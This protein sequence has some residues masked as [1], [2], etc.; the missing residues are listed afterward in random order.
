MVFSSE[1]F[2][3]GFM[4][5]F[6]SLYYLIANRHKNWLI[7]AASLIFY[8]IGEQWFVM[9]MVGSILWNYFMG[10]AIDHC[11]ERARRSL[12]V[13]GVIVNLAVIA[14]FKYGGF[15]I[16]NLNQLLPA[17]HLT[18]VTN[19]KIHLAAGI[20]F[21]TF[22]ALS[23]LIDVYRREVKPMR[24][25]TMNKRMKIQIR[26]QSCPQRL[27]TQLRATPPGRCVPLL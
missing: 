22:H 15:L 12:L 20:S 13:I 26:S 8:T 19:P 14:T 16:E 1:L 23:Y 2:I 10:L 3:Y 5:I 7:L 9:L 4:P 11:L 6:F 27:V 17:L 21:F 24:S 25:L 18:P